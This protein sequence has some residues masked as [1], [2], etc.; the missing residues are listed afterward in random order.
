MLTRA[1]AAAPKE[2]RDERSENEISRYFKYKRA[3][4]F[5]S[6]ARRETGTARRLNRELEA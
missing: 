3:L 4:G 1:R 2:V 6:K 5:G